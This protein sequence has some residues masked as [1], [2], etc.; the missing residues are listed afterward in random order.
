VAVSGLK[1]QS[2][3]WGLLNTLLLLLLVG[4]LFFCSW[5]NNKAVI[6][7]YELSRLRTEEKNLLEQQDKLQAE[8]ATLLR[9][10]NLARLA[11][12]LGL[13]EPQPGHKVV[14]P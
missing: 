5:I 4:A 1:L 13:R 6:R 9:P 8:L 10:Q 11:R 3:R 7:G 14:L 2:S 12:E